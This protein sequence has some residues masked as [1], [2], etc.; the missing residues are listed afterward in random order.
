LGFIYELYWK[1][2]DKVSLPL[3]LL[4]ARFPKTNQLENQLF[5]FSANQSDFADST[6]VRG[7]E[8]LSQRID[9]VAGDFIFFQ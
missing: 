7:S 3:D 2:W 6:L 5:H 9:E 1:N 8:K 4:L